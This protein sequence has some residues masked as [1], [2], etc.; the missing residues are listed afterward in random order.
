M[1]KRYVLFFLFLICLIS[2][3]AKKTVI[4]NFPLFGKF[5]ILDPGHGGLDPG[6]VY[7]NEYE[8]DYNLN[9]SL[10]LKKN[11]EKYG[12]TVI[13]TREGDYDLSSPNTAYRKRSD[14]DNRIKLI[15]SSKADLYLSL[16]MNSLNNSTYFGSQSFYSNVNKNNKLLAEILQNNFNKFFNYDKDYK[17]IDNSKYMYKNINTVGVLIE[18]GFI[19]NY[20]DRKNL[21]NETYRL[22][23]SEVI[24][25]SIIEYFT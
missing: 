18:Y 8:K 3:A 17:L 5:I 16:H 19:T 11:L 22:E 20:K 4:N 24:S 9:F 1:K 7:K 14:F 6:S 15:E 23:L 13:M 10:S 12:A 21:K 25:Q 2:V